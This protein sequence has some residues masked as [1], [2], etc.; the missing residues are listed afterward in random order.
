[1]MAHKRQTFD[2]HISALSGGNKFP[3]SSRTNIKDRISMWEGKEP[4]GSSEQRASIKKTESFKTAEQLSI[5]SCWKASNKEKENFGQENGHSRSRSPGD[6]GVQS[7]GN[8]RR[9]TPNENCKTESPVDENDVQ[10]QEKEKENVEKLEDSRPAAAKQQ[11]QVGT[12]RKHNDREIT[13]QSDKD[14]KAVFTLF[15]RLEAMGDKYGRT[16]TELGNYFSPPSKD[17]QMEPKKKEA[18]VVGQT[19]TTAP[20]RARS[21]DQENLYMEPGAPPINPVPKPQRTFRH[22]AS[23]P[24]EV[25]QRQKR[26]QRK[27]PPLP[28]I[29]TKACSK[30][31]SGF[32]RRARGERLRD[33][34]TNR[35]MATA[36]HTK[37]QSSQIIVVI[38]QLITQKRR[39]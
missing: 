22:P 37:L 7:K 30:P 1:M 13:K 15:K 24:I 31:P 39:S 14:K 5:D 29:S 19:N 36:L 34:I 2:P 18:E 16:P 3:R 20:G 21:T 33:N 35:Y 25:S 10:N 26:G 12:L 32:H 17:E 8:L 6:A 11:Q 9:P 27:L 28:S 38:A 23:P 4:C